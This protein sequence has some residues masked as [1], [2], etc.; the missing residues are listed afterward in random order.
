MS[1]NEFQIPMGDPKGPVADPASANQ[2]EEKPEPKPEPLKEEVKKEEPKKEEV[3]KAPEPKKPNKVTRTIGIIIGILLCVVSIPVIVINCYIIIQGLVNPNQVPSVG[4]TTPLIVLTDSMY[5]TIQGGD[6]IIVNK[7][8]PKNIKAGDVIAYFDPAATS[9]TAVVS[10]RVTDVTTADGQVAWKTK[11]DA[12]TGADKLPVPASK[13]V[14]KFNGTRFAG[15]GSFCMWLKSVPGII[16]C[17]GIPLLLLIGYD[18]IRRRIYAKK[19]EKTEDQLRAE[20]EELKKK[21]AQA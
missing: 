8:D 5:P 9:G 7:E 20:L 17:V 13:F 11:G 1:E 2:N 19:Q 3:Q 16:V 21:Q 15:I 18:I 12:N 6:L 4:N 10:H 14:G